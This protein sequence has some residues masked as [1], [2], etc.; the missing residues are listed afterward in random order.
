[1]LNNAADGE[2]IGVE[3]DAY[4]QVAL[5]CK[6]ARPK[7]QKWIGDVPEDEPDSMGESWLRTRLS[8]VEE[9]REGTKSWVER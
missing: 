8:R 5:F 1:M 7:I 6:Q 3:G 2:R 4:Q 9:E